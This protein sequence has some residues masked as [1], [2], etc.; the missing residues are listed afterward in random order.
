[1]RFIRKQMRK[2]SMILC[3]VLVIT[4]IPIGEARA[5]SGVV[6][7]TSDGGTIRMKTGDTM[8][9]EVG[10]SIQYFGYTYTVS[11]CTY[12]VEESV[13][14][15][16]DAS[17]NLK[18]LRAGYAGVTVTVYTMDS[19]DNDYDY[20][21]DEWYGYGMEQNL[22]TA[23]YD[24]YVSPD[25]SDVKL[26]T[27][28]Q[29]GYT[30]N[31]WSCPT[32]T[33]H[34][35]SKDVLTEDWDSVHVSCSSSNAKI[36]VY[37]DLV[38]NVLTITP[39]TT[40]KTTVTVSINDQKIGKVTINTIL[41]R[42]SVNSALLAIKQAKQLTVKG[43]KGAAVKWSSSNPGVASV[44][45]RGLIRAKKT[46]NAVIK[47]QVGNYMFGCAVSVVTASRQKAINTA[48]HMV[49]TGTYSQAKRM[50][51][52]FYDCSSLV[53]RS[54][55]KNGVTFGNASYAPVAADLC[56]W[57]TQKKKMLKGGLSQKNIDNMKINAGD[58]MF[59]T[60]E[61]NGRYRG[62]YHVEM[63]TGYTCVGFD[64]NGKPILR[65]K[66][67]ARAE[68]YADGCGEPVGRL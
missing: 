4:M 34:L 5:D 33:F 26:D 54:Y 36:G 3:L 64:Y 7:I 47:A 61:N 20:D 12:S 8:K 50:Q 25:L 21:G 24:V 13:A 17:G 30:D 16:V 68:G 51:N 43:V 42:M 2:W 22:F 15:S 58:L 48:I 38:N 57:C 63:I 10:S 31:S 46:G 18:A 39:D 41:V 66:Y 32:Y 49:K 60:G 62:I 44:S 11:R 14:V 59:R 52:G 6:T 53:W 23:Y 65:L 45:S 55:H 19:Y 27:A 67:A 28:S 29:I 37:A 40:G 1:M 35:K 9:F 56:K